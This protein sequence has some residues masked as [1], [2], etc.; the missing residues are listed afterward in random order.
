MFRPLADR[1]LVRPDPVEKT[2][3][4]GI[5]IPET[6]QERPMH[7]EILA[8]GPGKRDAKGRIRPLDVK[9]GDRIMFGMRAGH[10][11]TIDGE[12]L[13]VMQQA[14]IMGLTNGD[15]PQV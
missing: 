3:R 6:A 15:G 10:E 11:H 7:G 12:T 1:I 9:P 2:S 14:D 4:G 13:R 8:V 5:M